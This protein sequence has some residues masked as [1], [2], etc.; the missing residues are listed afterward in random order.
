[1]QVGQGTAEVYYAD[2]CRPT[3]QTPDQEEPGLNPPRRARLEVDCN[4]G[5]KLLVKHTD[6]K[7]DLSDLRQCHLQ[8]LQV[9]TMMYP[10]FFKPENKISISRG[11]QALIFFTSQ[12]MR[13]ITSTVTIIPKS[14]IQIPIPI[15]SIIFL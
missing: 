3:R 14:H 1:V 7:N 6:R 5:R 9:V 2:S 15:P 11:F 10:Q 8:A 13:S 12:R 4:S